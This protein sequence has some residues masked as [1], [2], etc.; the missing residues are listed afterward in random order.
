MAVALARG[1]RVGLVALGTVT[2]AGP[3]MRGNKGKIAVIGK[4]IAEAGEEGARGEAAGV[5]A[6][7]V[8]ALAADLEAVVVGVVAAALEVGALEVQEVLEGQEGRIAIVRSSIGRSSTF[9]GI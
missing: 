3:L 5:L 6:G 2:L 8:E 4:G 9:G 1:G 7:A